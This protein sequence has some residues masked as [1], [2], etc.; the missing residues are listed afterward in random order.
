MFTFSPEV[1]PTAFIV[2]IRI[3]YMVV[4]TFLKGL[5]AACK[6]PQ[7]LILSWMIS[8]RKLLAKAVLWVKIQRRQLWF[9]ILCMFPPPWALNIEPP[10]SYSKS[11]AI[12]VHGSFSHAIIKASFCTKNISRIPSSPCT[13]SPTS[14]C[15][16]LGPVLSSGFQ[17]LGADLVNCSPFFNFHSWDFSKSRV[18]WNTFTW[19]VQAVIL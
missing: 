13:S 8:I 1:W 5:M 18:F 3:K 7:Y 11:A 14:F 16:Q 9:N 15:A 17:A 2:S 19:I 4:A 12:S 10:A 6:S